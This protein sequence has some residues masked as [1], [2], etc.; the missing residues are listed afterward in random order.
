MINLAHFIRNAAF[1]TGF[2]AAVV[3]ML[4]LG[5]VRPAYPDSYAPPSFTSR[6]VASLGGN[7]GSTSFVAQSGATTQCNLS[8]T[9]V[10][11]ALGVAVNASGGMTLLN[12]SIAAGHCIEWSAGGL[13]DAGAACSSFTPAG[14][15]GSIQTNNGAGGLGSITPGTNVSTM[16]GNATNTAGGATT[17]F[18]KHSGSDDQ[19][20]PFW[21]VYS[22]SASSAY[23]AGTVY[24]GP[25]KQDES[26]HTD[27]IQVYIRT[28]GTSYINLA[29]Y[30]DAVDAQGRHYP[31]SPY[32][33]TTTPQADTATGMVTFPMSTS[34]PIPVGENW[35]CFQT[36]DTTVVMVG[37]PPYISTLMRLTGIPSGA[38]LTGNGFS[39]GIQT[40]AS[41]YPNWPTNSAVGGTGTVTS[42]VP[43]A[44]YRVYSNP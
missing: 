19:M 28:V 12:G 37:L 21:D 5:N 22:Y 9:G 43:E 2:A 23:A 15:S 38:G 14:S 6:S 18:F 13:Q 35:L 4:A 20:Y 31:S 26:V 34:A 39:G 30:S 16:L 25:F 40:F 36:D 42:E 29:L 11:T 33:P 44:Q 17:L 41:T 27:E 1:A 32:N 10:F 8:G 3:V 24:C 7:C